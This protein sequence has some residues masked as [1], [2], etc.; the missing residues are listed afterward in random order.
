LMS[1]ARKDVA[2][3]RPALESRAKAA[4]TAAKADLAGIAEREAAALTALLTAQRD[5]IRQ[6]AAGKDTDQLEFDLTD[7]TERR[8]RETDRRHWQARLESLELELAREPGRVA[9]SY[10][11]RAERIEPVGVVYLWPRKA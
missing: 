10:S 8:Q 6:A 7:P 9:E 11:V 5:R 4:A 3:L 1:G 2:D